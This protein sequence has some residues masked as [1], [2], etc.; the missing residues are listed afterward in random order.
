MS[1]AFIGRKSELALLERCA[2][3]KIA[4]LIVI[5]GRRR[6]GKSRLADEFGKKKNY[7]TFTGLAP[8]AGMTAQIQ[9]DEFARRLGSYFSLPGLQ[10][11]DWGDLFTILAKQCS[12]D[13]AVILFDEISWMGMHDVTFL[14]KLRNAWDREFKPNHRLT[15]ILCGSISVWIDKNILSSTGFVGRVNHV[16]HLDELPLD[17]CMKFWRG[18]KNISAYEKL[19]YLSITGGVPL[20]LENLN[21]SI[22]SEE[23]IRQLCFTSGGLLVREFD[24]IFSDLFGSARS[25]IKKSLML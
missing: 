11:N 19:K 22:T 21:P 16:I 9:R 15:M 13:A 1:V 5:E 17:D 8:K 10:A 7:Y 24:N 4:N 12:H 23:N 3:S 20:Y 14:S 2:Q 6:I 18:Q 25:F